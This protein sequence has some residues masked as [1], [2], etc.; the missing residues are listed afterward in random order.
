[1]KNEIKLSIIIFS[2]TFIILGLP[3][4]Y[5][6]FTFDDWGLIYNC[7]IEKISDI[8][9]FFKKNIIEYVVPEKIISGSFF[10]VFYRPINC[11]L[12]AVQKIFFGFNAYY[13]F[14]VTIFF[15]ALNAVI[16]FFIF[17]GMFPLAAS[18][19]GALTFAF[20]PALLSWLGWVAGQV[21]VINLTL[22]LLFFISFKKYLE[23]KKISNYF[24][25]CFL[26]L[27]SLFNR[28]T[29]IVAPVLVFFGSYFYENDFQFHIK[30]FFKNI[31]KYFM[32]ALG[33]I[34]VDFFYLAVRV[35]YFPLRSLSF[36][37]HL[38]LNPL[39]FLNLKTRFLDLVT[40]VVDCLA[41]SWLPG[42]IR[43]IKGIIILIVGGLFLLLFYTNSKR[44]KI[45]VTFLGMLVLLWTD[46]L[47]C[48]Q[49]R[50]FY[51]ALPLLVLIYLYLF[52]FSS[53]ITK[54]SKKIVGYLI[55][56]LICNFI[57]FSI[58]N[59]KKREKLLAFPNERLDELVDN[60][61][62][63]NRNLCFI[64]L[65]FHPFRNSIDCAIKMRKANFN[66]VIYYS[67][68]M[69]LSC[70]LN[71]FPEEFTLVQIKNGFRLT[72][73]LGL[74][75]KTD[76]RSDR[77]VGKNYIINKMN[78]DK[79]VDASFVFDKTMLDQKLLFVAW[80]YNKQDFKI[81]DWDIKYLD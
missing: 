7:K 22:I 43:L 21:Y 1:M 11:L 59:F 18:F 3:Y 65:P 40:F 14:L 80:D 29:F 53:L 50:Y 79:V 71:E 42:N 76:N 25:A 39:Q 52:N 61:S 56:I 26:L 16:V 20:H 47:A 38:H 10:T 28:E 63:K 8:F 31:K 64:G 60:D 13:Y 68:M 4:L 27:V 35:Y 45:V 23:T 69:F 24:I 74:M 36:G 5:W 32:L 75:C 67:E 70:D 81:L 44:R 66:N 55:T 54:K 37:T 57:V 77:L 33:F 51:E 72:S 62:I 30:D 58:I 78:G 73:S 41:L 34:L 12:Y 46:F 17:T 49:T 19:L 48:Y 6:G 2:M 9:I 15:H